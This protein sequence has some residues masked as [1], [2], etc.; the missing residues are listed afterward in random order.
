MLLAFL[1]CGHGDLR[2]LRLGAGRRSGPHGADEVG[3]EVDDAEHG[4]E[5]V[6]VVEAAAVDGVAEPRGAALDEGDERAAEEE[7]ERE[8]GEEEAGA[9]GLHALGRPGDEEVQLPRVDER[10]A[11]AHQQELRRQ[12]EHANGQRRLVVLPRRGG[13]DGEALLLADGRSGHA[14]DGEDQTRADLLQVGEPLPAGHEAPAERDEDAVVDGEGE[15]DGADEEDGE[16]CGRDLEAA[17]APVHGGRLLHGEGDHL[18]VDGPEQDR[19]R[20]HWHQPRHHLHLLHAGHGA[21]LPRVG[22]R[23]PV[24]PHLVVLVAG[25][26]RRP[27]QARELGGVGDAGVLWAILVERGGGGRLLDAPLLGGGDEDLEDLHDGA[28]GA[29]LVAVAPG[30]GEEDGDGE[31]HGA[32]ADAVGPAPADVVLDVDEDGDGEER[33]DADEEE[34]AVEEEAHGCALAGVALVELVGAEARDAG[35]EPASAERDEVEAHVEHAHLE[36]RRLLARPRRA[37]SARRRPQLPH[38]RG[39]RQEPR[40][41]R[42]CKHY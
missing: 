3:A 31:Q 28:P 6:E 12:H 4:E 17:H 20:P 25:H 41:L 7:A 19:R 34:E 39:H 24:A 21:E 23:Q 42:A 40:A 18:R 5:P 9:H 13:G 1:V 16:R 29:A 36:P 33:A 27:V 37:G 15:H 2:L 10:L 8:R 22:H 38:L 14:D 30:A 26:H 11:G 32:G 35:L